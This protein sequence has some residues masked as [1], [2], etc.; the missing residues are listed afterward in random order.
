MLSSPQIQ[1]LQGSMPESVESEDPPMRQ[2]AALSSSL[3]AA[4]C[5]ASLA[6]QPS[7]M[8]DVN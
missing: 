5:A 4:E 7:A 2:G 3:G 8:H 1:D 6:Q